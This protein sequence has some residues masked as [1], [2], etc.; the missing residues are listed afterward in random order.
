MKDKVNIYVLLPM[1]L[2]CNS[3]HLFRS[4]TTLYNVDT[5]QYSTLT[6]ES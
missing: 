6:T 4:I 1:T 2:A 5:I 3:Y